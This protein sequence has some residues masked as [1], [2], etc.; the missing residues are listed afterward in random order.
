M[1][2]SQP[3]AAATE[4]TVSDLMSDPG[5]VVERSAHLAAA[6]YLMRHTQR[7][8]LIVVDGEPS[9]TPVGI[10]TAF[11][12]VRAVSHAGDPSVE[13]V[14]AW[15]SANAKFVRPETPLREAFDLLLDETP[16]HLPVVDD[17]DK[18]VGVIDLI[19][20]ARAVRPLLDD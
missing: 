6:A 14:A 11:D 3:P 7:P 20:V 4:R 1:V 5:A 19:R 17:D 8:A 15:E 16:P 10:I 2:N 13:T 18:L 9:H 12:I